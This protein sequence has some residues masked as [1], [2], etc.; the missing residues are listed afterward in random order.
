MA[1]SLLVVVV[2]LRN[3]GVGLVRADGRYALVLKVDLGRGIESLFQA[4]GTYQR[5][6]AVDLV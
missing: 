1:D 4:V 5:G 2:S 3:R 6:R